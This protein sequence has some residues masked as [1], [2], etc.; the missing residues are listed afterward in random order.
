[1]S[2]KYEDINRNFGF[3]NNHAQLPYKISN[4]C[5]L[6]FGLGSDQGYDQG[7][8]HGSAQRDRQGRIRRL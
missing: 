8:D 4:Y 7:S 2:E 3:R 5:D 1:M 6:H